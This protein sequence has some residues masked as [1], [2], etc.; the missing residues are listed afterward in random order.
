MIIEE[1]YISSSDYAVLTPEQQDK[2]K[3]ITITDEAYAVCEFLEMLT[4]VINNKK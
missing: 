4:N 3:R 2:E 1:K